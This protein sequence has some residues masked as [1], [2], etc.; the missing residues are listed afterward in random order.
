MYAPAEVRRPAAGHRPLPRSWSTRFWTGRASTAAHDRGAAAA[1][2]A[3]GAAGPAACRQPDPRGTD[4]LAIQQIKIPK[5]EF[6]VGPPHPDRRVV[7]NVRRQA[8]LQHESAKPGVARR[9]PPGGWR[10][11]RDDLRSLGPGDRRLLRTQRRGQLRRHDLL[12]AGRLRRRTRMFDLCS[13]LVRAEKYA[14]IAD[15]VL[16]NIT[17]CPNSCSPYRIADIGLRGLRDPRRGRLDRG[18]PGHRRRHATALRPA[19]GRVQDRAIASRVVAAVLDTFLRHPPR[20]GDLG[21]QRGPAGRR[22]RTARRSTALGIDYAK[23]VNP[24]EL[25]VVAGRGRDGG[26]SQDARSATCPA[27]PPARPTPTSPST[28]ATSPTGDF[29]DAHRIN[30]EDNVLARTSWG[31]SA[32]GPA[33]PA[34]ATSGPASSG[35]SRICHLKRVC[36]RRQDPAQPAAAAVLRGLGQAGGDHRRRAGRTG[37]RARTAPLGHDVTLLERESYLGGQIRIGVPTFRLPR[38]V[39]EDDIRAII[40]SGIEVRYDTRRR[41]RPHATTCSRRYDA[42]LLAAGANQPRSLDLRRPAA[43]RGDRG[44]AIHEAFQR[45]PAAA[46]ARATWCRRRRVYGRRLR[47]DRAAAAGPDRATSRIM[48]RRGEAQM[49]A[50]RRGAGGDARERIRHRDAGLAGRRACRA[51][52][53]PRRHLPP[54]L[55]PRAGRARREARHPPRAPA[56]SS[57]CPATRS[58]RPSARRRTARMLPAGRAARRRI[59]GR[60]RPNLFL[61][62]D[63]SSGTADVIHAVADGK[64]VAAEIDEFLI[65]RRRRVER[66]RV[67]A[68]A[69]LT[70]RLRDHDLVEPPPMPVCRLP[71]EAGTTRSSWA[72]SA[73]GRQQR[74]PGAATCAITS[75]RSTRTSASTA[76]GASRFRRGTAFCRLGRLERD[77]DGSRPLAGPRCPADAADATTYIWIDSDQCIRCGNCI[78]ICPVDAISVRTL[79]CVAEDREGAVGNG[80]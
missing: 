26:R 3:P 44:P 68:E 58:F 32:R 16:V 48:Y 69:D 49:A 4:G 74:T 10:E 19:G 78:N 23:A 9:R 55:A 11:L 50:S 57:T 24:L 43:R 15:R 76:T 42:V 2:A 67:A 36:R 64:A 31:G 27:A 41:S 40:H 37:R 5:G 1:E 79:E 28:S 46:G 80:R 30:Q 8:R 12:P 22:S 52:A 38:D 7:G 77:A 65:G 39:L 51:G 20:R 17:G 25:S 71:G 56:A 35:R 63:F 75:S 72:S 73:R 59:S 66:V 14:P 70:G 33:R 34:A 29:D 21:G 6:A 62:G 61:A 47:P 54:Q 18:L 53:A 60:R 13:D 45:G